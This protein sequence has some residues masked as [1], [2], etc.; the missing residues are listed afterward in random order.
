[1]QKPRM[2]LKLNAKVCVIF[3]KIGSNQNL[4]NIGDNNK[5]SVL[6]QSA[7]IYKKEVYRQSLTDNDTFDRKNLCSEI[8]LYQTQWFKFHRGNNLISPCG[9]VDD[10]ISSLVT[11]LCI[12]LT[13]QENLCNYVPRH[14]AIQCRSLWGRLN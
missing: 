14:F 3:S 10:A 9:T 1:M 8:L 12:L 4:C 13:N 2:T 7:C 11:A 6:E 5:S